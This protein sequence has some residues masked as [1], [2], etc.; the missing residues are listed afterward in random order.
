MFMLKQCCKAGGVDP[1]VPWLPL[2]P[3][4]VGFWLEAPPIYVYHLT[5]VLRLFTLSLPL[6][7]EMS[8][9]TSS[10]SWRKVPT[11]FLISLL[12]NALSCNISR[13]I[14]RAKNGTFI[15]P[16]PKNPWAKSLGELRSQA[17]RRF[18]S[19]ERSLHARNQFQEFS[20]VIEEYL[21]LGHAEAVPVADLQKPSREVFYLPIMCTLSGR[22]IALQLRFK[23]FLT[24]PPSRALVYHWMIHSL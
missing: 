10:G 3:D 14:T 9:F 1:L 12:K 13:K 15:V 17:V 5:I 4:L 16:L 7:L 23:V 22:S 2:K 21:D 18:L 6:P 11:A 24:L 8:L 20:T 19:L